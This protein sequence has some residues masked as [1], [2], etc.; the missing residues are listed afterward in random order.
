[1]GLTPD[2][3]LEATLWSIKEEKQLDTLTDQ[4]QES[5]RKDSTG[6]IIDTDDEYVRIRTTNYQRAKGI[7]S[8]L[9]ELG[10]ELDTIGHGQQLSEVANEHVDE[11]VN[12]L[13]SE[14]ENER[15]D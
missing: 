5:T 7:R 13:E 10:L 11:F 2:Y 14:L 12:E 15:S 8:T 1:M 3:Q 4:V 6:L 9:Q